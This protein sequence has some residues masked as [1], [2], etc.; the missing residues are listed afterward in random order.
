MGVKTLVS[1]EEYLTS[2]YDPDV[3]YV[4]GELEDRYAGEKDHAKFQVRM[5]QLFEIGR[6]HV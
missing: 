6:A 3:D 2:V 5:L 4:D 1:V